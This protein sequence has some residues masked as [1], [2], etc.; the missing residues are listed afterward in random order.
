MEITRT[1]LGILVIKTD[2]FF[3]ERGFFAEIFNDK[4]YKELGFNHK[5]LQDSISV[6]K[7]GVTRGL[8]FQKKPKAQGKLIQ[9]LKGE[10]FDVAVNINKNSQNFGKHEAFFLTRGMQIF[11]PDDFAHGFQSLQDDS[12][13]IYK[14]TNVHSKEHECTVMWND[15]LLN[16]K[17]P[18]SNPIIS[19]K[20]LH[21]GIKLS[22]L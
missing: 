1:G 13:I 3:D 5:F 15:P 18:I 19:Q 14:S 7:Y 12:T 6:S 17:W 10:I 2:C 4:R 22:K 16:I 9:V 20:D 11:I 21:T 8:H